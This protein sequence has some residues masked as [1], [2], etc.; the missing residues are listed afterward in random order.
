MQANNHSLTHLTS[1]RGLAA[2]WVVL[3]HIHVYLQD[4]LSEPLIFL[5]SKGYLAVD[6]FFILSG[7]IISLSYNEKINLFEFSTISTFFKKRFARVYPLHFVVLIIYI[8]IPLI[9]SFYGKS[10]PDQN[11]F[12]INNFILSFLLINNWGLSEN[13]SWNIPSWSISTE[14]AAYL[15]FPLLCTLI[16]NLNTR[17]CWFLMLLAI[18]ILTYIFSNETQILSLGNNI[19]KFGVYRCMLE[20]FLGMCVWK[21]YVANYSNFRMGFFYLIISFIILFLYLNGS[22]IEVVSVPLGLCF[23]LLGLLCNRTIINK[24]LQITPIIFLGEISYSIYLNH[25]FLKEVFKIVFMSNEKNGASII[26]IISYVLS[27]I[28]ISFLTY[29]FIE[30]PFR[31]RLS[32]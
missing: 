27:V 16:K 18:S 1:L 15:S 25:Y 17:T 9:F 23:F 19:S 12:S 5:I 20:F 8:S 22:L 13:L 32:R 7:F 2:L 31:N 29:K 28:F 6:F 21:I 24:I 30:V 10:F 14:F 26:W 4:Y 11:R 3:Y